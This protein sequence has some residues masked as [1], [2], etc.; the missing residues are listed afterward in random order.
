MAK[1]VYNACYGGFGLS[2][3][4][5]EAYLKKIG[6]N[7]TQAPSTLGFM[8]DMFEV[9]GEYFSTHDISR[10]DPN[11]VAVVEELGE[12]ANT[13][14]SKL[15]IAELTPGTLYRIDEYDGYESVMTI[16]DYE[17]SEA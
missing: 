3:E 14:F 2:N 6:A 5:T 10:T 7:Y 17:W 1:V 9:D 12:A 4:A 11:L 13:R 15:T 8:G 16:S